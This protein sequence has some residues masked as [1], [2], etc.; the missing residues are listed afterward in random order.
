MSYKSIKGN[1]MDTGS[2]YFE[3]QKAKDSIASQLISVN[4]FKIY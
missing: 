3:K 4:F 1:T 2:Y